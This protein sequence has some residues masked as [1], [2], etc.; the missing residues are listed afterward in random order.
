LI[1]AQFYPAVS[2]AKCSKNIANLLP[3]AKYLGS[4]PDHKVGVEDQQGE[5]CS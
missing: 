3:F 5:A 2:T 4:K 1:L